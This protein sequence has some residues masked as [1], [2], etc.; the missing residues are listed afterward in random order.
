[1]ARDLLELFPH[2]CSRTESIRET[3]A[4]KS[5]AEAS[6]RTR[7]R[8][9]LWVAVIGALGAWAIVIPYLGPLLGL[10]LELRGV[11]GSGV[12]ASVEF[13]DHVVPGLV[14]VVLSGISVILL[15]TR[16]AAPSGP[17]ALAATSLCF[18]A[19]FWVTSTHVPL[20][21]EAGQGLVAWGPALFHN[22][23][24]LPIAALSLILLLSQLG[25]SEE[26]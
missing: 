10:R 18:L 12:P 9:V 7:G 23:A 25:A 2:R 4:V 1:M 6:A 11:P 3:G 16:R 13:V 17:F 19:G 20:L 15:A 26:G 8:P 22:S 14:V 5:A 24:G 21:L